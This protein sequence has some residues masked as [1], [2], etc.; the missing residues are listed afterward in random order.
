MVTL[1]ESDKLNLE[2]DAVNISLESC[3]DGH[4][5]KQKSLE[6]KS[7]KINLD[8]G[9]IKTLNVNDY[10][11]VL[12]LTGVH[13]AYKVFRKYIDPMIT[14]NYYLYPDIASN[15][16]DSFI[17]TI[18]NFA[19][20]KGIDCILSIGCRTVMNCGRLISLLLS[21]KGLLHDYLPGGSIGPAGITADLI[22][23]ITVPIISG[24]GAEISGSAAFIVGQKKQT[25][26][27]PNLVPT[28]TYIDPE[29]MQG[30]PST[31]L[32][33]YNFECFAN[34]LAAY[35]SPYAN[36]MSDLFA[37]EALQNYVKFSLKLLKDTSSLEYIEQIEVASLN[38]FIATGLASTGAVH[39][40][41]D[42]IAA[43]FNIQYSVALAMIIARVHGY[44]YEYNKERYDEVLKIFGAPDNDIKKFIVRLITKI[45]ITVP[46][47]AG[48]MKEDDIR[49]IAI[50]CMNRD[51]MR[52]NPKIFTVIEVEKI[53]RKLL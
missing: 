19:R 1:E 17:Y 26:S 16:T 52:S 51:G 22:D 29:I 12:V 6:Q 13:D 14:T 50:D 4:D 42:V 9:V 32:A 2:S 53:L 11:N 21:Q 41:A 18:S 25:I 33:R 46:S 40:I 44:N 3:S 31:L 35:V 5:I 24:T 15:P 39:G 8:V 45:G 20:D 43:R 47:L 38:A 10:K 48:K 28:A 49:E 30:I 37:K 27:S 34:A 7:T 23:H 36:A